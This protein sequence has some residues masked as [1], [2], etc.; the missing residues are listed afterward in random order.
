VEVNLL[1]LNLA[2]LDI[3]FVPA[4]NDGDGL[5]NP[6]DVPVPIGHVLVCHARSDIEH[7]DRAVALD[8]IA[9]KDPNDREQR[10][11]GTVG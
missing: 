7:D 11:V 5:T 1:G 2:V 8:V 9:W 6:H 10:A 3:N 4:E